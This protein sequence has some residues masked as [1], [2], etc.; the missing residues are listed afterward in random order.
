MLSLMD[1]NPLA[2]AAKIDVQQHTKGCH[3]RKS[4]CLKKYCQC[5]Q[6]GIKCGPNCKCQD[7]KNDHP[8]EKD[9]ECLQRNS[10][11]TA[12]KEKRFNQV[13]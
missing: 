7:C 1:R 13:L 12:K 11:T 8:H 5:F 10:R 3:C 4:N 2:F 9:D 6:A